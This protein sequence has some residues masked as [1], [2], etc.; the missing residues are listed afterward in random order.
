MNPKRKSYQKAYQK[1]YYQ[2]K[3]IV[4]LENQSLK[5]YNKTEMGRNGLK[6]TDVSDVRTDKKIK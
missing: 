6:P 2:R 4:A 5:T 3:K 1:A